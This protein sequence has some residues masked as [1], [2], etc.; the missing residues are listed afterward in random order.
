MSKRSK[1]KKSANKQVMWPP[2]RDHRIH[3]VKTMK[4]RS[5]IFTVS[6]RPNHTSRGRSGRLTVA[7]P[8][9]SP[10]PGVIM[11]ASI[12]CSR[13]SRGYPVREGRG[14]A[15]PFPRPWFRAQPPT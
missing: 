6:V 12:S 10:A 7:A 14:P 8:P 3:P 5:Y 13:R 9:G 2:K 15:T 1:H 11:H 4:G